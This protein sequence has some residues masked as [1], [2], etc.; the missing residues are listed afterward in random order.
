MNRIDLK[1]KT[2]DELTQWMAEL[3]E[4]AFRA[5]QV[6]RWMHEGVTRFEQMT[7][8]PKKLRDTLERTCVL[9][10]PK[11]EQ[12]QI[13]AQD[14][15]IKYL[16]RLGDGNCV[17]TVLLRYQYG[18]TV[19]ISSQIGCRMGCTFCASTLGGLVRS[20]SPSEILDQVLF[21]QLESG[22]PVSNIVLMGI[23]EPL[24]NF[25]AVLRFLELVNHPDGMNIG[26]RHISL[27]TCGLTEK[28]DK[29]ASYRLQLTLSV[30]L[31]APDDET[32]SRL[33]P[34]NRTEGIKA[35]FDA[36]RRYFETTGRRVSY[37]YA[38]IDGINDSDAQADLLAD[39]LKGAPG[40]VNLIPLNYVEEREL[41]PSRR[42]ASFQKRLEAKGVA[43][44]VRR[45]LG[46]DI[47]ASCGQLRRKHLN[48]GGE[49]PS[50]NGESQKKEGKGKNGV[51]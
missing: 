4:P 25:D 16:W 29:L 27:S 8:L 5:K 24:D 43:V 34:V 15:T 1:S 49:K 12:K 42:V 46:S 26:M 31:H 41:K 14:G 22:L 38:M 6:F 44:T 35:V 30:S 45:K 10:A 48:G 28:I 33:M 17:E 3:G 21:T 36:C 32:R 47:D 39:C 37:E 20:L 51:V 13:S 7:N 11:V 40:H 19:C 23:G 50:R 2:V 9:T 18:N